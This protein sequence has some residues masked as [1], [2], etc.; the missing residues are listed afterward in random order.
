MP[1]M[2]TRREGL[3]PCSSI[4]TLDEADSGESGAAVLA[5]HIV[6]PCYSLPRYDSPSFSLFSLATSVRDWLCCEYRFLGYLPFVSAGSNKC[7]FTLRNLTASP[8]ASVTRYIE[9]TAIVIS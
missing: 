3:E 2:N 8:G 5:M 4:A 1:W 7:G 9:L 6:G